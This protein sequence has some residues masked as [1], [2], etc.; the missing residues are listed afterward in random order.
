MQKSIPSRRL[1]ALRVDSGVRDWLV[2]W[3]L[4][5]AVSGAWRFV[6]SPRRTFQQ[7][8]DL[9]RDFHS[10]RKNYGFLADVRGRQ[11]STG[12]VLLVNRDNWVARAKLEGM[13]LKALQL[14]GL[15]PIILT[16]RANKRSI[17]YFRVLGYKDFVFWDELTSQ[18][19]T[20]PLQ[21][22]A[23]LLLA[24]VESVPDMLALRYRGAEIGRHVL[25]SVARTLKLGRVDLKQLKVAELVQRWTA[26]AMRSVLAAELLLDKVRPD[27]AI[28]LDKG[29]RTT[30]EIF[31][32][33]VSRNVPSIEWQHSHRFDALALRRYSKSNLDQDTFALS[34]QTWVRVRDMEW[35]EMHEAELM[36]GFGLAYEKGSWFNRKYLKVGQQLKSPDELRTQLG[37][38]PHKKTAVIF[39]HILWDSTF[40][41]QNLFD[42]YEQW[43]VETV[44]AACANRE[45]NWIVKL[46][47]DYVFD[48]DQPRDL[49]ALTGALGALP[50]HVKVLAPNTDINTFS[51]FSLTDYCI[52][53]RGTIGIEMSC[54]GIPVLT[55]GKARYSGLGFTIDSATV[56]EYLARLATLEQIPPL[57][58]EQTLLAK[59]HTYALL[60]L[61]PCPF[62]TFE[63]VRDLSRAGGP[64]E[65]NVVIRT[66]STEETENAAD[67]RLFAEW[68]TESTAGDFLVP[69]AQDVLGSVRVVGSSAGC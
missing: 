56:P 66:Q 47:P 36:K 20:S 6:R 60:N 32:V 31:D 1:T 28:F 42:D 67:L 43:L 11:P 34:P 23:D 48:G 54:F 59:K 33:A 50:S 55:A 58:P 22:E 26:E 18:V 8:Q 2:R 10:F 7:Q 38:D 40:F 62:T 46:H 9:N 16:E 29:Y 5:G 19:S 14:R 39:S 68:V 57:S 17:G 25:S 15:Q 52:T 21:A 24:K 3:G 13:L 4:F 53:V 69:A 49:A 41:Y 64:L 44:R 30:G 27:V 61:R 63:Q 12:R 45:L 65:Y 51:L 35:T 37:L